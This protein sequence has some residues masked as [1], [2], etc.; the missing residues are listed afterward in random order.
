MY[1]LRAITTS[2]QKQWLADIAAAADAA[3]KL[4]APKFLNPES[5]RSSNVSISP[6]Q[7]ALAADL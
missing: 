7:W 2:M 3:V 4:P 1:Q 6:P 5:G